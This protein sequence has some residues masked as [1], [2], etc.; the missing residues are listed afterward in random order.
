MHFPDVSGTHYNF[1]VNIN[2]YATDQ[3]TII[4]CDVIL[5]QSLLRF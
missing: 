1:I 2:I 4:L 5:N 3:L